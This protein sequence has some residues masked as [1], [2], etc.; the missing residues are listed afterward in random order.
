MCLTL[1]PTGLEIKGQWLAGECSQSA[2]PKGESLGQNRG[3]VLNP[4]C[5]CFFSEQNTS[6]PPPLP[7]RTLFASNGVT[8]NPFVIVKSHLFGLQVGV[9]FST[10]CTWLQFPRVKPVFKGTP[11]LVPCGSHTLW[12]WDADRWLAQVISGCVILLAVCSVL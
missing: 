5:F 6:L 4:S 9:C 10:C 3:L 2:L 7:L 12:P 11:G 8:G 1:K